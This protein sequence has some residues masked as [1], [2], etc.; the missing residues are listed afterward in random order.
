MGFHPPLV[1]ARLLPGFYS[2]LIVMFPYQGNQGKVNQMLFHHKD[3]GREKKKPNLSA[4]RHFRSRLGPTRARLTL[5]R[6]CREVHSMSCTDSAR[7]RKIW[8]AASTQRARQ[9]PGQFAHHSAAGSHLS[10]SCVCKACGL[11]PA[12]APPGCR[13]SG[14]RSSGK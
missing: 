3:L 10:L 8:R 6:V 5:M 4:P 2:S 13:Q 9:S 1:F 12:W 7:R 14:A 11:K